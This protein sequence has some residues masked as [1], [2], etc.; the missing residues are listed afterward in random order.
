ML[1]NMEKGNS[2]PFSVHC[3]Q[4]KIIIPCHSSTTWCRGVVLEEEEEEAC[5]GLLG[6]HAHTEYNLLRVPCSEALKQGSATV[7]GRVPKTPP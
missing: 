1:L 2:Y 3:F 4:S 6:L 7:L 5:K